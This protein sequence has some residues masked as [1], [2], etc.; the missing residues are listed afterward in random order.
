VI[1]PNLEDQKYLVVLKSVKKTISI[2]KLRTNSPELHSEIGCCKIPKTPWKEIIYHICDTKRVE[3]EFFFLLECLVYTQIRSQ[4]NHHRSN[5]HEKVSPV[6]M[7]KI[8]SI[9]TLAQIV[10]LAQRYKTTLKFY[11]AWCS[12]GVKKWR[13]CFRLEVLDGKGTQIL[14]MLSSLHGLCH[15]SKETPIAPGDEQPILVPSLH[16][17]LVEDATPDLA[18][19]LKET[20]LDMAPCYKPTT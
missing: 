12:K 14:Q 3:D 10:L 7:E 13:T 5:L 4:C 2:A 15:P 19:T 18:P 16:R 8:R 20:P 1:N 11:K 9:P 17:S 6:A